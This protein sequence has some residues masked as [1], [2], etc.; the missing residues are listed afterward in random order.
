MSHAVFI[1]PSVLMH[2]SIKLIPLGFEAQI[3]KPSR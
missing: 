2:K 3:K 1:L